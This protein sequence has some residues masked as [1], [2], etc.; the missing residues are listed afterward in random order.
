[1]RWPAVQF[2]LL[3]AFTLATVLA[4]VFATAPVKAEELD[5]TF[6]EVTLSPERGVAGQKR[7][8]RV[9]VLTENWFSGATDFPHLNV[10]PGFV[11]QPK[12]FAI[13]STSRR[14]G[15]MYAAQSREYGI[16][17]D[18]EGR[19]VVP[20]FDLL[21]RVAQSG[22]QGGVP[23]S[24]ERK[25]RQLPLVFEV[26]P[27]PDGVDL[28]ASDLS[29]EQSFDMSLDDLSAGDMLTRTLTLKA[30]DS[31]AILLPDIEGAAPDFVRQYRQPPVLQ[32]RQVRGEYTAVKQQQIAYLFERP[33]SYRLPPI[34]LK[35]WNSAS[36]S[37]ESARLDAVTVEV[38]V[39]PVS[40]HRSSTV[41]GWLI[42]LLVITSLAAVGVLVVRNVSWT[43]V[44]RCVVSI[45]ERL[46][47][48]VFKRTPK[49]A[50]QPLN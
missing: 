33:G 9:T 12:G 39:S 35:W 30:N 7:T 26:D 48:N 20:P 21:A 25:L 40:S 1:M 41:V 29:L 17:P 28:V 24:V 34:E 13:N 14:H 45:I 38:A 50:L 8:L 6:I 15:K 44:N 11:Q 31:L 36:R 47:T 42:G 27:L 19:L 4:V 3:C 22:E 46:R 49:H 18:T 43:G 32:D 23:F 37:L 10:S 5:D 16:F 2:H